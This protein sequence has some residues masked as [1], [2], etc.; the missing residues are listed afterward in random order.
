LGAL[1][2]LCAAIGSATAAGDG[3]P[4]YVTQ[5]GDG[6][7]RGKVRYVAFATGDG[8]VLEVINRRGGQVVNYSV[9]PGN[10]GIP[11]VAYDGTAGGLFQDG[12]RLILGDVAGGGQELRRSSSFAVVDVRRLRVIDTIRLH[13]D[14]AF[15]ALSPNGR[16]LYLIQHVSLPGSTYRV[17]AY[18]RLQGRLL[19]KTVSD[20][21]RWQSVMQGVPVAR[22]A[23]RDGRWAYTLYGGNDHPFVH[24]LDTA[25]A[26]AVCID[27][28]V[29]K[30]PK[31]HFMLRLKFDREGRLVV[32]TAKGRLAA[33][34][35]THSLRV[36]R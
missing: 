31:N 25:K 35:D 7:A 20:T 34:I 19:P 29:R 12:R 5:G 4:V 21:R 9:L 15:D 36:L 11:L 23:T 32:R 28:P 3:G 27:L 26:K 33:V 22:A 16:T 1:G 17:R 30:L 10:Y 14:F 13:G 8:T 2:V 6:I 24:A 18:D